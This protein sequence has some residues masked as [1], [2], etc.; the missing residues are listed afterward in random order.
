[1]R[2][3]TIAV[4]KKHLGKL[5]LLERISIHPWIEPIVDFYYDIRA[6][7]EWIKRS[8]D[9]AKFGW[10]AWDFDA[11]TIERYLLFKLKRVEHCLINGNCDLTVEM[12]PKKMKA[13]KLTIKLLERLNKDYHR[14]G[15]MHDA[16]WGEMETWFE[17]TERGDGSSYWRSKRPKANTPELEEQERKEFREAYM[18]DGR[19]EERDRRLVYAL[20]N[21]YIRYWWD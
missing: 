14:F 16:K 20:I 7:I 4:I 3:N 21:K 2:I 11:L 5:T 18:A 13:I 1:M 12:G 15:D 19:E 8:Y 9:Y 17:P 6:R 10:Q